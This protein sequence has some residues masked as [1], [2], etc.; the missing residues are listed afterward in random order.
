MLVEPKRSPAVEAIQLVVAVTALMWV[1]EAADSLIF[2]HSLDRQGIVP[3]KWGGLDGIL[4]APWLHGSFGHL[5]ANTLPFLLLGGLVALGGIRRWVSVTLF[6]MIVGGLATWLLARPAIHIGASG[7]I[8]GYAGFL[9][10]AGFVEKSLKGVAVAL[11]V[12]ILFGG[13]VLHGVVPV[14]SWVSWE[15]HL[16]GLVAGVLAAFVIADPEVATTSPS[17]Q[18]PS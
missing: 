2:H 8:F 1:V 5:L 6:V 18:A 9:L 13:V 15:S 3:R 7:L 10:V 14:A 4:W 17:N 12:G 11:V 16:F